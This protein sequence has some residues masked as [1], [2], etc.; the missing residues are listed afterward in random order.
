MA[1]D[2]Q[3]DTEVPLLKE[4][5]QA[6]RSSGSGGLLIPPYD[7]QGFTYYGSTNNINTI[8]YKTGGS[9]GTTVATLVFTYVAAGA[10]DDD[11]ILTITKI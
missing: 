1:Q 10:A 7:Y 11:D 4:L 8:V 6:V 2:T 9:G 3:G 5:L